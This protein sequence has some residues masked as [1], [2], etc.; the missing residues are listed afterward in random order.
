VIGDDFDGCLRKRIDG[1]YAVVI[2]FDEE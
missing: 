1:G 2:D